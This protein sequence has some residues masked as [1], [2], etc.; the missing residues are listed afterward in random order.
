VDFVGDRLDRVAGHVDERAADRQ[1][2]VG[3]VYGALEQRVGVW[4]AV[5]IAGR[6]LGEVELDAAVV[7]RIAVAVA[8]I[9]VTRIA[10]AVA[11]ITV[12]G[13]AVAVARGLG[14]RDRGDAR[15]IRARRIS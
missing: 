7:A 4:A 12:A 14:R 2:H 8:R 6:E 5:A 10:V 13:I 3:R 9:A 1:H 11:G 15:R